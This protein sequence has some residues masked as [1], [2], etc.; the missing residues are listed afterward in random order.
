MYTFEKNYI[1]EWPSLT[2]YIYIYLFPCFPCLT[3]RSV[4]SSLQK[5]NDVQNSFPASTAKH[6]GDTACDSAFL[7]RTCTDLW[8]TIDCNIQFW[9]SALRVIICDFVAFPRRVF[10]RTMS[11]S[12]SNIK[13]DRA[14]I[15]SAP[16]K[17]DLAPQ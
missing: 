16:T 15:I 14:S 13:R 8:Q 2:L 12:S 6:N 9:S 3:A 10:D 5:T 17:V 7:S 11:S 4:C 1:E